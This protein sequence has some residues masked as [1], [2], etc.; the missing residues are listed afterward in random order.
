MNWTEC[1]IVVI[2]IHSSGSTIRDFQLVTENISFPERYNPYEGK[3]E[4]LICVGFPQQNPKF[5]G[6]S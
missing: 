2:S 1:D 6:M 4:R 5:V 3:A